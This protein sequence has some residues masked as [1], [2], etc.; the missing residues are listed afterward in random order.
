MEPIK[1]VLADDEPII[2]RGL[3]KL[4]AWEE[5]GLTISGEA[6][7]GEEL[8]QLIAA[9][10]PQLVISDISMP[11]GSGLEIMSD[12]N[13]SG[14][15]IK[16]IFISAFQ[17][18]SYAQ[19]AVQLGALDY[20]VK[21]IN[22]NQLE[23]VVRKAVSMIREESMDER[24]KEK[25]SYY[26]KKNRS[27]TIEQ[28]LDG[29]LNGDQKA[30]AELEDIR[31]LGI[32]RYATVSVLEMDEQ[33]DGSRW[34]ERERNLVHFALSNII[35][36][37]LESLEETREKGLLLFKDGR[38]ALLLQ[39]DEPEAPN[40]LA[41][42]LL[43]KVQNYL[44]LR[45]SIGI[46][47][48]VTRIGEAKQSYRTSLKALDLK[49][50]IGP[51]RVIRQEDLKKEE[52]KSGDVQPGQSISELQSKL[53]QALPTQEKEVIQQITRQLLAQISVQAGYNK[54]LTITTVYNVLIG[55]NRELMKLTGGVEELLAKQGLMEELTRCSCYAEVEL[56]MMTILAD[57]Q[58]QLHGRL[59]GKEILVLSKVKSYIE[60]HYASHIT[61]ESIAALAYM[62]PYYF[63]SFF[64]KHTG[65]NFKSYVTEVRMEHALQL[66][67]ETDLLVYEIA[68]RVGYNHVRHFSDMFKKKYGQVP[69][70]YR[71][72]FRKQRS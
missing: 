51:H 25:L 67:L 29:L 11:G 12:L 62:N 16:V 48:A 33:A 9:H 50:F 17:E 44:K 24:N 7:D 45:V 6:G 55:L 60:E 1:L 71:Q 2:L 21:P 40:Q 26:E 4:L 46:G 68:E 42:D 52:L 69:Q 27:T 37:T 14:R 49:Y 38:F 10:D 70:E 32:S 47:Q 23:A 58:Q 20:L 30:L 35:R 59:A 8:R 61:L 28:L 56:L 57:M 66:L 72:A 31:A 22:K 13:K 15:L 5:L 18:F 63:S 41:L 34:D 19:Q 39:H 53:A 64:K 36:E 65:Q 54:S 43:H 3:K